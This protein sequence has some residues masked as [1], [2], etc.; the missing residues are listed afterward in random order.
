MKVYLL[1]ECSW[2]YDHH[3]DFCGAFDS[4]ALAQLDLLNHVWHHD[5]P[6]SNTWGAEC[7]DGLQC[8]KV[9]GHRPNCDYKWKIYEVEV[10]C[11]AKV[12]T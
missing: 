7:M 4:L 12:M 6:D 5:E 3:E 1:F 2:D 11:S 8:K 9:G 10:K